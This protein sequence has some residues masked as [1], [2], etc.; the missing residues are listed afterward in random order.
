METPLYPHHMD[1][2]AKMVDFA[3]WQMPLQYTGILREHTHTRTICSLFDT[4]H[5]GEFSVE[6]SSAEADL[7]R[8]V[9]QTVHTLA[10]GQCRYG[11]LLNEAGGT[12][13]DLTVYRRGPDR[14][15]LVVNAG[16][17]DRDA[18]WIRDHI[19]SETR[20]ED[21]SEALAKLDLQGPQTPSLV[22]R[23]F[24][25]PLPPLK[26]F[27]FAE[28]EW[29]GIP[30]LISRTGYTG[31]WG[32]ELYF[33][34]G[35]AGTFWD[36]LLD[37]PSIEPAGLGARDTLR[38]EMGYPLYGHE[39]TEDRTPVGVSRG[40]FID[41][42]KSF[43]GDEAIRAELETGSEQLLCPLQLHTRRAARQGDAVYHHDEPVGVVTSGSLSPSLG[44][45][46]A[47]AHVDRAF[48]GRGQ[49]L[50]V[51]V[52][53]SRLTADVVDLPFYRNGTARKKT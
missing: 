48:T 26:F 15:F 1:R 12:L 28:V 34:A 4:C 31:E 38:L 10:E 25:R 9:T 44:V 7:E 51:D 47:L 13:D 50:Q 29:D 21:R 27:R 16:T 33:P 14:F 20:F 17:R 11:F 43:I 22:E 35:E 23:A 37:V 3:G 46:I 30:I 49:S 41:L 39:L 19:S 40:Q 42:E 5:M 2:G 18:D 8:L 6:G 53:G 36:R 52:R 24:G 32:V 45:A